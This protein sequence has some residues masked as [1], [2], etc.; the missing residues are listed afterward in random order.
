MNQNLVK[1][2]DESESQ[3]ILV[4]TEND[5]TILLATISSQFAGSIGLR[6]KCEAGLVA[7]KYSDHKFYPPTGGWSDTTYF[8]V[9]GENYCI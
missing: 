2:S 3:V 4:P 8:C 5:D 7:V 1:I 6:Y 9:Q